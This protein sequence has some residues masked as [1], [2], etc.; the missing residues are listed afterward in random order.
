MEASVTE[1]IKLDADQSDPRGA[2][3]A[4]KSLLGRFAAQYS[5]VAVPFEVI[6][7]DGSSQLFGRGVPAFRV[8]LK[9]RNAVRAISSIET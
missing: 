3:P 6:L 1:T 8:T 7:P 9:N 4:G 5:N 2:P